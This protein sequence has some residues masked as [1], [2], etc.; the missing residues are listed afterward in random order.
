MD[1]QRAAA[2]RALEPRLGHQFADLA[3]YR[4]LGVIASI[5]P[6]HCIDDM[7]W[8][9]KRIGPARSRDAYN[10]RSFTAAGIPV[11]FGTDWFVEPLDPRQHA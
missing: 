9:E 2:L 3:R 7:R 1:E 5:Q 10:F 6:S 11:A 4:A 8:A